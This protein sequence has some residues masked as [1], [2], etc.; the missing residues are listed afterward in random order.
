M[1][2]LFFKG[3]VDRRVDERMNELLT[4]NS[5]FHFIDIDDRNATKIMSDYILEQKKKNNNELTTYDFV[6]NLRL[7]AKQVDNIIENFERQNL[8]KEVQY[9]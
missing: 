8:V 7:P 3:A 1:W 2:N 5:D 6:I 9:A 4:G